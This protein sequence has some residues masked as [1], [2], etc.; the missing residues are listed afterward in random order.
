MDLDEWEIL[1]DGGFVDQ[2]E[3]Q[4][5]NKM[6][7]TT[8]IDMDYFENI[9]DQEKKKNNLMVI[10]VPIK[11]DH[12][13]EEEEE[14]I[15]EEEVTKLPIIESSYDQNFDDQEMISKVFFKKLKENQF[16][17]TKMDV[18]TYEF[19]KKGEKDENFGV[20][21]P[22]NDEKLVVYEEKKVKMEEDDEKEHENG[23]VKIW[24]WAMTGM[25]ALVSFGFA[26]ATVSLIV[27]SNKHKDGKNSKNQE[28]HFQIYSHDKR[29]KQVV[30]RAK[31]LNEAISVMRGAP[32][33]RAHITI[34]GYYEA[35]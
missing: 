17:D 13:Q 26:A 4:E 8:L 9:S 3:D 14:E 35:L 5:G 34:G 2:H 22:E 12:D 23:G 15:P 30:R 16:V 29:F 11:F 1:S 27:F 25:G 32:M 19:V 24:K 21:N 28:L 7:N 33:T 6:K 18:G 20:K 31:R 10:P